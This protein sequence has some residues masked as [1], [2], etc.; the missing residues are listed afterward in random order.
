MFRTTKKLLLVWPSPFL[1]LRAPLLVLHYDIYGES[2]L[3]KQVL[4]L[5]D[6]L[7]TAAISC[8]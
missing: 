8:G 7:I 5:L 2:S 3:S 1:A 4:G 6:Y